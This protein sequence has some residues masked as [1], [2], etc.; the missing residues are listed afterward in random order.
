MNIVRKDRAGEKQREEDRE[1]LKRNDKARTVEKLRE[2]AG[3][4]P[5]MSK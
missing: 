3:E 4:F 2:A 5:E 1:R